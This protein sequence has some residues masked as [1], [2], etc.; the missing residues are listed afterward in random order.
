MRDRAHDLLAEEDDLARA[1]A[2]TWARDA[3]KTFPRL[4]AEIDRLLGSTTTLRAT[5]L[6]L[7]AETIDAP[8]VQSTGWG[9]I[10]GDAQATAKRVQQLLSDKWTIVIAAEGAGSADRLREVF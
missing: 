10:T 6:S 5:S 1:L 9:P 4:H 8:S 3:E 2:S 7:P